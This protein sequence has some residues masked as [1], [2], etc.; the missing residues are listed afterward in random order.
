VEKKYFEFGTFVQ[1]Q[2]RKLSK[3]FYLVSISIVWFVFY[4]NYIFRI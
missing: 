1:K 4:F 3:W 2:T